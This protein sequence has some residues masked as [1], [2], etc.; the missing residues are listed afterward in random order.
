MQKIWDDFFKPDSRII[1]AGKC[2]VKQNQLEETELEETEAENIDNIE[3][4][5]IQLQALLEKLNMLHNNIP[6]LNEKDNIN[7][8]KKA[9]KE[10]KEQI[11]AINVAK[12]N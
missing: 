4:Y 5:D 12:Y 9:V 1:T 8:Q 6:N 10:V 7:D 11:K 3:T 2:I